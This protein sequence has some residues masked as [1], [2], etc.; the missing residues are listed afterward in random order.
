MYRIRPGAK[1]SRPYIS[2]HILV[3]DK[4]A[5]DILNLGIGLPKKKKKILVGLK[6]VRELRVCKTYDIFMFCS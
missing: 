3:T 2:T 1:S 6:R 4:S 5:K